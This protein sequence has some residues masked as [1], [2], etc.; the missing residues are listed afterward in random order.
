[1]TDQSVPAL[2]TKAIF[3]QLPSNG[4]ARHCIG[5]AAAMK[6]RQTLTRALPR[7]DTVI[8]YFRISKVP[9]RRKRSTGRWRSYRNG[10]LTECVWC[11][12]VIAAPIGDEAAN[13][14]DSRRAI[15]LQ[16]RADSRFSFR[17]V[18]PFASTWRISSLKSP[19]VAS[20]GVHCLNRLASTGLVAFVAG[21]RLEV[22]AACWPRR[23]FLVRGGT[24][25]Q[26]RSGDNG[27]RGNK[28]E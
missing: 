3:P 18:M 10:E 4:C 12:N 13:L 8:F 24:T 1:M 5:Y 16:W 21:I 23:P 19:F 25:C 17:P 9:F 6:A 26:T 20:C 14:H 15:Y 22:P 28:S 27:D 2:R 7:A 11:A